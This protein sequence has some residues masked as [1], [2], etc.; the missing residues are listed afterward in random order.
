MKLQDF[1]LYKKRDGQGFELIGTIYTTSF[2]E[3]KKELAEKCYN[4]LL[5][6]THGDNYIEKEDGIY[7]Y[8]E[9]EMSKEDLKDGI[10]IFRNDVYTWE[11]RNTFKFIGF[12]ED[13]D[14]VDEVWASSEE[15]AAKMMNYDSIVKIE[16]A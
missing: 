11:L 1:N 6:G 14:E 4:D 10:M 13:G 7:Y 15:E 12:D 16:K 5:N 3:A 2:E 9:L 8:S